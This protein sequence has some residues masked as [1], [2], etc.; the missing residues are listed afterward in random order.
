MAARLAEH[1]QSEKPSVPELKAPA[2]PATPSPAAKREDTPA[3]STRNP[4]P[5]LTPLSPIPDAAKEPLAVT[6]GIR[7]V[8][9]DA[10]TVPDYVDPS[11]AQNAP[12]LQIPRIFDDITTGDELD[13]PDFLK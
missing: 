5:R 6:S 12:A 11:R 9:P 7:P 2:F 3:P 4:E 10:S 13:I 1:R 8:S